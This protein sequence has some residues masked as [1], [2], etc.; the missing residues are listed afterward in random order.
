MI[1]GVPFG[2]EE[3]VRVFTTRAKWDAAAAAANKLD[4][5]F[6]AS[7]GIRVA[8]PRF[9]RAAFCSIAGPVICAGRSLHCR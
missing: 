2:G 8:E 4:N 3:T 9:M 1:N 7:R 5:E 6:L